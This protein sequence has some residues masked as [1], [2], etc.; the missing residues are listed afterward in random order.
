MISGMPIFLRTRIR[1]VPTLLGSL[2]PR[3]FSEIT[4]SMLAAREFH[5]RRV[6]ADD[7][8]RTER[9]RADMHRVYTCVCVTSCVYMYLFRVV[10]IH[11]SVS[12]R[13]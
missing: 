7:I 6:V 2:V 5:S 12:R 10:Y 8:F 4:T 1:T 11:V 9:A 3:P 13:V